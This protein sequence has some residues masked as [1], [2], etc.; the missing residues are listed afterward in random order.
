MKKA[1]ILLCLT[2]LTMP[3]V[4]SAQIGRPAPPKISF[5][6]MDADIRNVLRV[7]ADVS[8]K[9][10][11]IAED[12]KGKIT[13]KLDNV[14]HEEALE[15]VLRSGD[16]ARIEEENIVRVMTAKKL[17]EER[18]RASKERSDFRKEQEEKRRTEEDLVNQTIPIF[19]T[20]AEHV[21]KMVKGEMSSIAKDV[22]ETAGKDRKVKTSYILVIK[23]L[24]N[25][26][27]S[28]TEII[29]FVVLYRE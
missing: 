15:V 18:I 8:K 29:P 23:V 17:D 14:S 20:D 19:Y 1:I 12:V 5:D 13:L 2:I 4:V 6:F 16:L 24:Q 3:F 9:N 26:I 28:H 22:A 27:E 10:I 25:F 21:E 7:L 11:V